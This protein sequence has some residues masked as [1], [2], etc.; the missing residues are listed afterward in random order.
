MKQQ[1]N[2]LKKKRYNKVKNLLSR[3]E[4]EDVKH[5][6][7]II[8][9]TQRGASTYNVPATTVKKNAGKYRQQTSMR[10]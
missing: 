5:F 9:R 7:G 3:S 10:E 2:F 1:N 4:S 6:S 8:P